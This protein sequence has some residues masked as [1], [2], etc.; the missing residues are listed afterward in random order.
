[1]VQPGTGGVEEAGKKLKRKDS[2]K[3]EERG[4]VL[5]S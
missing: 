4:D 1:V 2:G 5:H 3:K